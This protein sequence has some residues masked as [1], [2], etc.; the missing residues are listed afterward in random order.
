MGE[1]S[2]ECQNEKKKEREAT[3]KNFIRFIKEETGLVNVPLFPKN[4]VV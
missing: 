4:A 2:D 1:S 3:L